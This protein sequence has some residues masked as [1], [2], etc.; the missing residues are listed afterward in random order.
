MV[1]HITEIREKLGDGTIIVF[2]SNTLYIYNQIN[3]T[4]CNSFQD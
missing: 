2:R 3:I 1:E 4:I